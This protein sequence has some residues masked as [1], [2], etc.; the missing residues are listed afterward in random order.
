[1][2][3]PSPNPNPRTRA[4]DWHLSFFFEDGASYDDLF[5]HAWGAKIGNE[6]F[7]TAVGYY[8]THMRIRTGHALIQLSRSVTRSEL[9][10]Y[11]GTQV[12][13]Y[14]LYPVRGHVMPP[15]LVDRLEH[16]HGTFATFSVKEM[17]T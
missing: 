13:A 12:G 11:I 15:T 6:S 9:E 16:S 10:A 3:R 8:V 1:M 14:C 7:V 4:A 17:Y 2:S 5:K